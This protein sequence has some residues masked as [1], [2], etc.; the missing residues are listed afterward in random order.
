[1]FEE[2]EIAAIVTDTQS[3]YIAPI[4]EV[5]SLSSTVCVKQDSIELALQTPLSIQTTIQ[6][7]IKTLFGHINTSTAGNTLW[8]TK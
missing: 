4:P 3:I 7:K 1:M 6:T 5:D 2:V 8:Q